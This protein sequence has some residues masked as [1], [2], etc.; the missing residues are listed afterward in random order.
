[1]NPIG[2]TYHTSQ[3]LTFYTRMMNLEYHISNEKNM[4][5]KN[6]PSIWKCYN[7]TPTNPIY[8]RLNQI[9]MSYNTH[10]YKSIVSGS[11]NEF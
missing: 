3:R 4:L 1:M 9:V 2:K 10:V 8:R 11:A 6:G 7:K 5:L